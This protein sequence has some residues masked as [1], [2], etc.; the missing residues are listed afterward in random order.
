MVTTYSFSSFYTTDKEGKYLPRMPQ[1]KKWEY[2]R[3]C[4]W[5]IT[6]TIQPINYVEKFGHTESSD[7]S[8]LICNIRFM[9]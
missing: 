3:K 5:D 2:N 9:D 8:G 4:T 6:I 1:G 7:I